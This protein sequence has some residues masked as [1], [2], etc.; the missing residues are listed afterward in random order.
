MNGKEKGESMSRKVEQWG[1][2][3]LIGMYKVLRNAEQI[4]F[5]IL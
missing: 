5:F 1:K 4:E 2:M 3:Y